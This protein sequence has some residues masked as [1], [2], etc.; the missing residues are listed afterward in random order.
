M[1]FVVRC[2]GTAVLDVVIALRVV[3][4]IVCPHVIQVM[5]RFR[6]LSLSAARVKHVWV[7]VHFFRFILT[8]R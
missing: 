6:V 2:S 5:R 8:E 7:H 1:V 3:K 4:F